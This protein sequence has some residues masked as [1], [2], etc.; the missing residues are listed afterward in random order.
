MLPPGNVAISK[1]EVREA[2]LS[3]PGQGSGSQV[4]GSGGISVPSKRDSA[5]RV[6]LGLCAEPV[7]C[8]SEHNR[9]ETDRSQFVENEGQQLPNANPVYLLRDWTTHS[10]P[11]FMLPA[12]REI[13]NG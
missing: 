10:G 13:A 3:R 12:I 1:R 7:P 5:P 6:C 4:A 2:R 9:R 8:L 11:E